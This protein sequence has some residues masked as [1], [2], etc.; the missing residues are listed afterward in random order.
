MFQFKREN[1]LKAERVVTPKFAEGYAR[2]T[3]DKGN[4][5]EKDRTV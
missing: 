5:R 2:D 1:L 4:H 3:R